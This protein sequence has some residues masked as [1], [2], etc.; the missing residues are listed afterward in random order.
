MINFPWPENAGITARQRT[1]RA[2]HSDKSGWVINLVLAGE[3]E[4]EIWGQGAFEMYVVFTF[5]QDGKEWMEEVLIYEA[6]LIV[7][8]SGQYSIFHGREIGSGRAVL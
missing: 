1:Y 5:R 4:Q 3:G 6:E 2:E 8:G 7:D